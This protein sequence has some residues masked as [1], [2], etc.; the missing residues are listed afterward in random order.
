MAIVVDE[1][2]GT[3]GIV[4]MEDILEEIVGDI[5]DEYDDEEQQY[6][7]VADDTYI[8]E[9]KTL[10][11]DFYKITGLDEDIFKDKTED[12]ETLAGLI[13]G[14]KEDFPKVKEH[15]VYDC[16]DFLVLEIDK[17]RIIKVKVKINSENISDK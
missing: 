5:S 17:R 4:T 2:G 11:N 6:I 7:R 3:S 15:I 8:F 10:L 13:L 1:F 14:I 9:G 16:C 12:V